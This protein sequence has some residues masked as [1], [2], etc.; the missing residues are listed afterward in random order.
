V[1]IQSLT[2]LAVGHRTLQIEMDTLEFPMSELKEQVNALGHL[3]IVVS[4]M[5]I[6]ILQDLQIGILQEIKSRG[7]EAHQELTKIMDE[8]AQL[9]QQY[10]IC[11]PVEEGI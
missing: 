4:R 6:Q 2:Q 9:Q 1:C 11:T 3:N 10:D 7:D 8:R 5:S